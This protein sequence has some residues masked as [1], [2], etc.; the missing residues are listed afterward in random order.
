[1]FVRNISALRRAGARGEEVDLPPAF[2]Q[3]HAVQRAIM[4][5]EGA[6][7]LGALQRRH[8]DR[9]SARLNAFLDEG[10]GIDDARRREALDSRTR[11]QREYSQFLLG[12]D[13]VITPPA[14]GEAPATLEV[15]GDPTFC[16]IWTL[17]GAP[18]VSIPVGLGPRGL[19]LGLQIVGAYGRDD[20]LLG[21]AAWCE[22]LFPFAGPIV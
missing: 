9:L 18:A 20:A 11:L 4:A 12:F 5:G 13:A 2:N 16:T 6:R 19:P 7:N 10:A 1:M 21:A 22:R 15:T 14:T 8:R 17:L 3:A